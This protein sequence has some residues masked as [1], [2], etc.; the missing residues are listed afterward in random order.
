MPLI[1]VDM[2]ETPTDPVLDI[3]TYKEQTDDL[4]NSMEETTAL[5]SQMADNMSQLS[6]SFE[7]FGS[8]ANRSDRAPTSISQSHSSVAA[9]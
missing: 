5:F 6:E 2:S 9:D 1:G 8:D 7:N 3:E 4:L